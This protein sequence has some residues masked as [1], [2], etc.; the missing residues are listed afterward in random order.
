[1]H[2]RTSLSV[3]ARH[4]TLTDTYNAN[5]MFVLMIFGVI[6][7]VIKMQFKHVIISNLI[8]DCY[9]WGNVR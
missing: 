8:I 1:M 4:R 3:D 6:I 2:E 7:Y 5:V 9:C